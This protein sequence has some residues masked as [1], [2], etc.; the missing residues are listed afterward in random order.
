[1][2]D[3]FEAYASENANEQP[4]SFAGCFSESSNNVAASS[5][6]SKSHGNLIECLLFENS[7]VDACF[8]R[9]LG[10]NGELCV[11]VR[12][13]ARQ[14]S[15]IPSSV[16][17]SQSMHLGVLATASHVVSTQTLFTV[18]YKPRNYNRNW[19]HFSPLGRFQVEVTKDS[20]GVHTNIRR[21]HRVSPWEIEL[22]NVS[23]PANNVLPEQEFAKNK[24]SHSMRGIE[25]YHGKVDGD[26]RYISIC[27]GV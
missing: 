2:V 24:R 16:I 14:Q 6:K 13:L 20:M 10:E 17:S 22:L 18:Y 8:V 26:P 11:G 21:P 23:I 7:R 19:R 4:S 27:T 12:W 25:G 5:R 3:I 15:T 1:M 9:V